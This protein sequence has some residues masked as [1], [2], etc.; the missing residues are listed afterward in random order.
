MGN[1]KEQCDGE[2]TVEA[3]RNSKGK[4]LMY[5]DSSSSVNIN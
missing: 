4:R 5:R 3:I 2:L 1:R